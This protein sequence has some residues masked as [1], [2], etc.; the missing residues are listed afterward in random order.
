[1]LVETQ[2]RTSLGGILADQL[3]ARADQIASEWLARLLERLPE[4]PHDIFPE[5]SL[6]DH[7][8]ELVERI[9]LSLASDA[10]IDDL[11]SAEVLH[12]IRLLAQLRRA[13]GYDL[14]ELFAELEVLGEVVAR[15][16][17]ELMGALSQPATAGEGASVASRF[18]RVLFA[19][20]LV[21]ADVFLQEGVRQ[22]LGRTEVL[23]SYARAVTHELK[24]RAQPALLG[25]QLA[26]SHLAAGRLREAEESLVR[27]QLNLERLDAIPTNLLGV[28]LGQQQ[29]LAFPVRQEPLD[30]VLRRSVESLVPYATVHQVQLRL[31]PDVPSLSVDSGRI[32]LVLVNLIGNA[33][34]YRDL[35]KPEHW[36]ALRAFELE[37]DGGVRIEIE[38]N[39][40]GIPEREL[41]KIFDDRFHARSSDSYQG[42]GLGLALAHEVLLQLGS[43]LLVDSAP[44][45]GTLFSFRLLRDAAG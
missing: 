36:V 29:L 4:A 22:R 45:R 20:G 26:R 30:R 5:R 6:L 34:K 8:P 43:R 21:G 25:M 19:M 23:A 44:G 14:H 38:D 16:V 24:N 9:S 18:Q 42:Q 39:G 40:V 41:G 7:V 11:L 2:E 10:E 28:V 3:R 1:V 37:D 15:H 32:Q 17:I 31:A 33:V 35:D 27:A 13:Q 12:E